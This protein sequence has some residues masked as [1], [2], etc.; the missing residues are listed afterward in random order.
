MTDKLSK[1]KLKNKAE[2]APY[3]KSDSTVG[4]L[5]LPN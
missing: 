1:D 3:P 4:I 2:N 5:E